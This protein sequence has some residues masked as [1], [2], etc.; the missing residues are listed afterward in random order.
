MNEYQR[1]IETGKTLLRLHGVN[2]STFKE[3]VSSLLHGTA[4]L[5]EDYWVDLYNSYAGCVG[6][7]GYEP[8]T[9]WAEEFFQG[10]NKEEHR[11]WLK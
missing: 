8:L 9:E 6:R 7:T 10:F 4:T 1:D 5:D 11:I 3:I 2:F